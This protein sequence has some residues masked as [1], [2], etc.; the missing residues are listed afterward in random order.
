MPISRRLARTVDHGKRDRIVTIQ[1]RSTE[2]VDAVGAPN[3]HGGWTTLVAAMP[4][5][6][7]DVMGA[8]K[9][10]N[11][12]TAARLD[13]RWEMNY[14]ADMD[15]E[16]VDVTATRRLLAGTVVHDIVQASVLGRREGIEVF[17]IASARVPA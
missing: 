10:V 17:T 12:Q 3:P 8:E 13:A 6:R 9:F 1:Q 5:F 16:V 11:S 4:V 15:P 14:R 7:Q 2:A